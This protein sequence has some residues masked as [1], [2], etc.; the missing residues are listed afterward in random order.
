MLFDGTP[1]SGQV[2]IKIAVDGNVVASAKAEYGTEITVPVTLEK[3]GLYD[4]AVYAE[5]SA[6]AGP[7][8]IVKDIFVGCDTPSGTT[9][10]L[11]YADGMM[12]LS[13]DP[14]TTS[15]NGGYFDPTDLTYTVTRYPGAIVVAEGDTGTGPDEDIPLHCHRHFGWRIIGAVNVEPS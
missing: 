6:G 2:D 4:F 9:V 3:S 5:N 1:A 12:Q 13:W 10:T 15:V 14:V 8:K 11:T 7:Q